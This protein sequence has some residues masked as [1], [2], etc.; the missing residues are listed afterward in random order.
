MLRQLRED[1]REF[2]PPAL[3]RL[4][5]DALEA[6]ALKIAPGDILDLLPDDEQAGREV[7]EHVDARLDQIA[8]PNLRERARRIVADLL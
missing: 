5:Q 4:L 1:A 6:D 8:D 3:A 2:D 7:A